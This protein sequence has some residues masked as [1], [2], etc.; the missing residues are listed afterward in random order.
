MS[1]GIQVIPIYLQFL[2]VYLEFQC[3]TTLE[4]HENE[5]KSVQWSK[6]GAFTA[7]CSRDKTVW[8]WEGLTVDQLFC[9]TVLLE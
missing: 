5:V 6:S 7:T 9:V 2:R 8:I 3:S 4:G 1:K